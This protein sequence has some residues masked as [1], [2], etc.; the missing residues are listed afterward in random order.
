MDAAFRMAPSA[1]G[2]LEASAGLQPV[3]P[4]MTFAPPL[5]TPAARPMVL[6]I[7]LASASVPEGFDVRELKLAIEKTGNVGAADGEGTAATQWDYMDA[8]HAEERA[9]AQLRQ[10]A[11]MRMQFVFRK[12]AQVH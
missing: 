1:D 8:E 4:V 6:S 9:S 7:P 5:E 10:V 3:G 11:G 2:A 12:A